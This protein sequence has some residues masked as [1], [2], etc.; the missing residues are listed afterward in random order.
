MKSDGVP[1]GAPATGFGGTADAR[2]NV[3]LVAGG[4]IAL[5]AAVALS[6]VALE[7]RRG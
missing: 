5:L 1:S 6:V 3:P 7:R 4:L 2:D